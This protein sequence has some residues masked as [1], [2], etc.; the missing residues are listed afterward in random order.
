MRVFGTCQGASTVRRKTLDRK[1]SMISMFEVEAVPHSYIP[2]VE[3]CLSI[4]LYMRFFFRK[5]GT[6][7]R[8]QVAVAQSV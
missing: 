1:R 2:Q 3:I 6:R 8:R 7:F 4:A 5:V